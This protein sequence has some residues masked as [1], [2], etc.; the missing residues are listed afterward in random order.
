MEKR[1]LALSLLVLVILTSGCVD[2]DS[3]ST[4]Q[5]STDS[6][7]VHSLDV[8]PQEIYEGSSV[9]VSLD[10]ANTGQLEADVSA[11][12]NGGSIMRDHCRD[13]FDISEFSSQPETLADNPGE[14]QTLYPDQEAKLRWTLDHVGNANQLID[15]DCILKFEVPFDYSVSAYRQIQIKQDQAVEGTETLQSESSSGPLLFAVETVGGTGD[16][17]RQTFIEEEDDSLRILL[18][19]QNTQKTDYNKGVI[20]IYEETLE[21]GADSPLDFS[22]NYSEMTDESEETHCEINDDNPIRIHEG[23]SRDIICDF[24]LSNVDVSRPSMVSEITAS[25]DYRYLKDAGERTVTVKPD[26]S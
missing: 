23:S 2:G 14:P 3:S 8:N 16:E 22:E 1:D 18:R 12:E 15:Q 7:S 11:G 20:E 4:E 6:I 5:E 25:V 13:M 24:D 17:G 21:V 9:R 10:L 19:L 26:G